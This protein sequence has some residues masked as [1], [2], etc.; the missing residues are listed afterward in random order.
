[1]HVQKHGAR[2]RSVLTS[3]GWRP[4]AIVDVD[5]SLD[6]LVHVSTPQAIHNALLM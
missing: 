4:P 1:V 5:W 2:L 6:Y 3:I